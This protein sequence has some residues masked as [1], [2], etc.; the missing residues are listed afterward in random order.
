VLGAV[1]GDEDDGVAAVE[2]GGDLAVGVGFVGVDEGGGLGIR[3]PLRREA[4]I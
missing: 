3:P 1:D 2:G 4:S